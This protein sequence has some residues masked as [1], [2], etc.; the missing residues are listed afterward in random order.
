[1]RANVPGQAVVTGVARPARRE[2]ADILNGS[3]PDLF[4]L[5]PCW[6]PFGT[7]WCAVRR[8]DA[9]GHRVSVHSPARPARLDPVPGPPAQRRSEGVKLRRAI[10]LVVMTLV[11]PGSAQL[12]AGSRQLGRIAVRVWL[13]L[14]VVVGLVVVL[15]LTWRSVAI[16]LAA[17]QLALGVVQVLL[18]LV[19]VAWASLLVDAW[20]L[21]RP[22]ELGRQH[23]LGFA[24]VS[25]GLAVALCA[26]GLAGSIVVAGQRDLMRSIFAGGGST[27]VDKGRY[28]I[29]LLGGDAGSDRTGVRP[30]SITVASVDAE[31]GRTVLFGLPRN[32]EDVP[33][34]E[35]S[36]LHQ[37]FPQGF[38]C[39]DHACLLNAVY[40]YATEH[41]ELYPGVSDP[42][43]QATK[44]AV[45]GATGLK[46]N[47]YALIEI[48]SFEKLIDAVGGITLDIGQ[49]VPIGGGGS[50]VRGY[51]EP[52]RDV[53]LDGYHAV[54]FARSRHGSSD[55]ARMARQKCVMRSMLDQL[56][57]VTVLTQF[58]TIAGAGKEIV[59]TDVPG[60][61]A[62]RLVELALEAKDKPIT[63]VSFTPPAIY[64]GSPDYTKIRQ[65]VQTRVDTAEAADAP[66]A[67]PTRA[68]TPA[69][70]T[71][72]A[73]SGPGTPQPSAS[74]ASDSAGDEDLD[75]VC[76]VR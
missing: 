66:K 21:G 16:A 49:R 48:G 9:K 5:L 3:S 45:E 17:S 52:G 33:F 13:A 2:P 35:S 64:P 40:T 75:A 24:V 23:R 6:R 18:V 51:I 8:P 63:S 37:V 67:D 70:P 4:T 14:L 29:L 57:P 19:G 12:A 65:L 10:F 46:I 36:P 7:S 11:L 28:N 42:G 72:P 44:E 76:T 55:Y 26:G 43:A 27:Q 31:T 60:S 1:M 56:D 34:P 38:T 59:A 73:A 39:A 47:Y 54:W 74:T 41:P 32:L 68:A 61:D 15:A 62:D 20:R 69:A 22:P 53:H 71:K 58:N 25:L 50:P 30:D